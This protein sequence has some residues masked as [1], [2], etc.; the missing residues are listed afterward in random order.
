[1]AGL[2]SPSAVCGR[3]WQAG[4]QDGVRHGT[5]LHVADESLYP[6]GVRFIG[7]NGWISAA[8]LSQTMS[9]D[10]G[11]GGKHGRWRPLEASRKS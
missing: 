5:L 4:R 11:A 3:A 8:W 1:V 9:N 2:N 7:E 10:P 6:N